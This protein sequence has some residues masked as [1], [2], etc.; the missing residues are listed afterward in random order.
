[1][2]K[3]R[4]INNEIS[5]SEFI[6]LMYE[7][8]ASLFEYSSYLK[9]TE[10]D[11]ISISNRGVIFTLN[12]GIKLQA[13]ERDYRV[14]PIEILNFSSYEEKYWNYAL[15]RLYH[16]KCIIDIGANIGY[17]TLYCNR[18]LN[19]SDCQ[20]Y[21][22]E[23]IPETFKYLKNNLHLNNITNAIA[24]NIGLSD[25]E[26]EMLIN[27]NS[28]NCGSSSLMNI[29]DHK[30]TSK[31][32][33]KFTTLDNFVDTYN[34]RRVDLIKC[35]VEGAEKLVFEGGGGVL[36]KDQPIIYCEMLRKWTAKFNYHPN[37][38]INKLNGYGYHCYA[39]NIDQIRPI[40]T[41]NENTTET[42]YL[43]ITNSD[44]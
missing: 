10:I 40:K 17:F 29:I 7:Q 11:E 22:L 34:I 9:S 31:I 39:L 32:L 33:C 25:T 38:I 19:Q 42:N 6:K 44:N 18:I 21:C 27:Y 14:I 30:T 24:C 37:D 13:I 5:K 23:P 16:P 28:S 3:Q 26:Q 15:Q 8:H 43:F 2:L 41:V 36:L 1:M 35:D 4:Y 12:N 20:Y